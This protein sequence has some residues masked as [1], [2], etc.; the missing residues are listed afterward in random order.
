MAHP[1]ELCP[2][3]P[4]SFELHY[5]GSTEYSF[6]LNFSRPAHPIV[7]QYFTVRFMTLLSLPLHHALTL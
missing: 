4:S 5:L 2:F 7:G 3:R 6:T 1:V